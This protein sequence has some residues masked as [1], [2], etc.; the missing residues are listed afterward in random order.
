MK[1]VAYTLNLGAFKSL[2]VQV[3]NCEQVL[4]W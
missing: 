4:K 1:D 3:L 2:G